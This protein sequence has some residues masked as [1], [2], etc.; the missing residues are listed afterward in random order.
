VEADFVVFAAGVNAAGTNSGAKPGPVE[1]FQRLNPAYVPPRLRR[2]LVFELEAPHGLP[3]GLEQELHFIE[4]GSD[5]LRLEMCSLLPKTSYITVVLVGRSVDESK[6]TVEN[7]RIIKQF[8]ELPHIG[9]LLPPRTSLRVTCICN[10]WLTVGTARNA[11]ADRV[12]AV[13]D[14]VTARLYKDGIFSAHQTSQTLAEA[15]LTW[16][17]DRRSLEEAYA[18]IVSKFRR[19]N[20]YAAM[21]FLAHRI[22]FSSSILSRI[23]YQA[24]ITERKSKP[25]NQRPLASLLW[26]TASGDEDYEVIFRLLIQPTAIWTVVAGGGLITLRNFLTEILF[27]LKW[28]GFGRFTTGVAK[29]RFEMKRRA[30][31]RDIHGAGKKGSEGFEFE[32]MYTIRVRASADSVRQQLEQFGEPERGYLRPRLVH[33]ERIAGQPNQP[34]C[35]IRYR[36]LGGLLSF[37]LELE[38]IQDGRLIIYRVQNGFARGGVLL[39][40]IDPAASQSTNL[41]IYLAFD[42]ERGRTRRARCF[43]GAFRFIFPEFV[44]DVIWNH[45]LCQLK[46]LA[47][48]GEA[49]A[50]PALI[51][52]EPALA[53]Q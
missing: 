4:Y 16:G 8:L 27:G 38:R 30:F 52:A 41:S 47:E 50:H 3:A 13:G 7:W 23:L 6:T 44:H 18:P 40:E 11:F 51:K 45:A 1:L 35:V 48:A 25:A 34:G 28:E 22:I 29:E 17:T 37:C 10:P 42:F 39:F 21:V 33:I 32:R 9:K 5:T 12:A 26:K 19:D 15:L 31:A 2:S 43:W 49:G 36:V 53:C 20:R 46:N 24:V 14:M